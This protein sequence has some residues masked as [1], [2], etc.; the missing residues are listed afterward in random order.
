MSLIGSLKEVF[1]L[2][3]QKELIERLKPIALNLQKVYSSILILETLNDKKFLSE[4]HKKSFIFIKLE[5]IENHGEIIAFE[6]S[7]RELSQK[8]NYETLKN[9]ETEQ[10]FNNFLI[11]IDINKNIIKIA[12]E[13]REIFEKLKNSLNSISSKEGEEIEKMLEE[14][15]FNT[16]RLKEINSRFS[17]LLRTNTELMF[18]NI[19]YQKLQQ[20]K[21]VTLSDLADVIDEILDSEFSDKIIVSFKFD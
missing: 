21:K 12:L 2:E 11:N 15:K 19:Y 13:R 5:K 4:I 18:I 8:T 1:N 3:K 14:V 7:L 10:A 17:Q 6:R 9:I 16:N 20:G